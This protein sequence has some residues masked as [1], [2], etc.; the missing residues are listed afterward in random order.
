MS[1]VPFI[2][3]FTALI[4]MGDYYWHGCKGERD[5]SKAAKYYTLAAKKGDPH[6]SFFQPVFFTSLF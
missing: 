5:V 6:V 3:F 2:C 1:S 4:K